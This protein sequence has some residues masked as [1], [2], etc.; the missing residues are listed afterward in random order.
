MVIIG[1]H[2]PASLFR[3]HAALCHAPAPENKE[4]ARKAKPRIKHRTRVAPLFPNEA[5][6][7]RLVSAIFWKPVKNGKQ[8]KFFLN[9]KPLCSQI[10]S[11]E[12]MLLYV[13]R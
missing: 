1:N 9:W 6:I 8:A 10:E 2:H 11:I 12:K 13:K 4:P 7:L 5:P 3:I